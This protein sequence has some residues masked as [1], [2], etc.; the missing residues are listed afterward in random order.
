MGLKQTAAA[1]V[2]SNPNMPNVVV[3]AAFG[4]N[5][6][7]WTQSVDYTWDIQGLTWT[8]ISS[9]CFGKGDEAT[10]T[11]KRGRQYEL[12]QEETGE[13]EILLDNH[14]GVFTSGNT[15]SPYY[16]NVVPGVPIRV[17][18]WWQGTQYPVAF[19]YAEKWPQ[20]WPDMPQWGFSTLTAMDAYG[21][22]AAVDRCRPL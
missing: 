4:A 22:L 6:G 20:A 7:N 8:D 11:V 10:I 13:I 5:P 19:G 15:A 18:A 1:P 9:R 2:Q 16:P 12:S 14:D 21:P 3:E 17:T